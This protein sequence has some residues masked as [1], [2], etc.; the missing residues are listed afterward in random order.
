MTRRCLHGSSMQLAD[1][2]LGVRANRTQSR[3]AKKLAG[4][5]LAPSLVQVTFYGRIPNLQQQPR[6]EL[7]MRC[8]LHEHF[9]NGL[10]QLGDCSPNARRA[11]TWCYGTWVG[12]A[13]VCDSASLASM[14]PYLHEAFK[15]VHKA[16]P[17][18]CC[19]SARFTKNIAWHYGI[20]QCRTGLLQ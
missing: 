14:A 10:S 17:T 9:I 4:N 11:S 2:L 8:L 12:E 7:A 6:V 20:M 15:D 13:T 18:H 3:K 1:L 16:E 19:C 5:R